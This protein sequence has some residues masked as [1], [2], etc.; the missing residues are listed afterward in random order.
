MA[1]RRVKHGL[2]CVVF[3][4][5][6]AGAQTPQPGPFVPNQYILLLEDAPVSARFL[7]REQMRTAAAVGY[8]QQV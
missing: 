7:S 8:R 6:A 2:L 1:L 4:S 5:L 3:L